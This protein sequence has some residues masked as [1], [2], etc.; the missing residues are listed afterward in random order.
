MRSQSRKQMIQR[1]LKERQRNVLA[2][3]GAHDFVILLDH[4]KAGYNVAK[5]LRSAE[6]FGAREVH[7]VG[8]GP[9]DPAPAKGA[10][11]KVPTR[12]HDD[13][14]ACCRELLA[15]GYTL[16]VLDPAGETTLPRAELPAQSAFVFGHEEFGTS[17]ERSDYPEIRSLAIPQFGDM[18]S[19]NVAVAASIVMYEYLRQHHP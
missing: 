19:L 10:L 9:F 16:F 7:L 3:P 8:I 14:A 4:L 12:F 11:R 17:F 13:F 1:Y 5:I 6:A 15:R 18:Q 2:R